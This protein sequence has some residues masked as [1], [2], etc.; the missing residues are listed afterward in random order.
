MTPKDKNS[1]EAQLTQLYRKV[2]YREPEPEANQS[3][4]RYLKKKPADTH[5]VENILKDS[6][7][8]RK[9]VQPAVTEIRKANA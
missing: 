4:L 6:F 1:P 2:L 3:Y 8:Y 9:L 5:Y 7:E